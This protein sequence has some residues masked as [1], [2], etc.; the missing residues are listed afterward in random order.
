MF[1]RRNK[2]EPWQ[3]HADTNALEGLDGAGAACRP[4]ED[5]CTR[6]Q[7][8]W[9]WSWSPFGMCH[10]LVPVG[11]E[12]QNNSKGLRAVARKNPGVRSWLKNA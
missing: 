5:V 6:A 8:Q 10:P 7:T 2:H 3:T 4:Q 11:R 1:R 12:A 9:S